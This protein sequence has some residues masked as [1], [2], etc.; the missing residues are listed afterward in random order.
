[1]MFPRSQ[2][3]SQIFSES[4]ELKSKPTVSNKTI[5]SKVEHLGRTIDYCEKKC[6]VNNRVINRI[7]E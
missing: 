3:C 7:I 5:F 4:S 2:G 6:R 1:M